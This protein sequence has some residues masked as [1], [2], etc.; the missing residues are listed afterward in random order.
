VV[1]AAQGKRGSKAR[2]QAQVAWMTVRMLGSWDGWIRTQVRRVLRCSSRRSEEGFEL[3]QE[4]EVHVRRFSSCSRRTI[5]EGFELLQDEMHV[6]RV[7]SC[8]R[9]RMLQAR[10]GGRCTGQGPRCSACSLLCHPI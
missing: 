4:D 6:R 3:L 8:A 2:P 9:R 1:H 10:Q 7:S 5:D